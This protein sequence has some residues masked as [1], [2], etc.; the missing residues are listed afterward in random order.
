MHPLAKKHLSLSSV[1]AANLFSPAVHTYN[2]AR[3]PWGGIPLQEHTCVMLDHKLPLPRFQSPAHISSTTAGKPKV[4]LAELP[5]SSTSPTPHVAPL[6]AGLTAAMQQSSVSS[7]TPSHQGTASFSSMWSPRQ[8]GYFS[9]CMCAQYLT[10]EVTG[11]HHGGHCA[12]LPTGSI[13]GSALQ[14]HKLQHH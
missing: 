5:R 13:S 1:S 8:K 2:A 3:P 4:Q 12:A 9:F 10:A 6:Q 11:S 14:T 7:S